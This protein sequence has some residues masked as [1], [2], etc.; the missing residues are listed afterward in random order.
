MCHY[1]GCRDNRKVMMSVIMPSVVAPLTVQLQQGVNDLSVLIHVSV[2]SMHPDSGWLHIG[3]DEVYQGP[4]LLKPS[5]SVINICHWE[6]SSLEN[7][8]VFE[9][10]S[11][12]TIDCNLAIGL[13]ELSI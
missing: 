10:Q 11:T 13:I 3:C 12:W 4:I 5:F 1:A 6:S 2:V 9:L 8:P 7:V